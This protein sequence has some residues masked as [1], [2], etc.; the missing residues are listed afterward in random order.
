MSDAF[1]PPVLSSPG[2]R[3]PVPLGKSGRKSNIYIPG[4]VL[5]PFFKGTS[6]FRGLWVS[7]LAL[8]WKLLSG[9]GSYFCDSG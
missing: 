4:S 9:H 2:Q 1:L 7:T 5:E 6:P 8:V 3:P